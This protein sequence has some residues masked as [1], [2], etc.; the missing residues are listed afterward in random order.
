M[1]VLAFEKYEVLCYTRIPRWLRR[2]ARCSS[3][4]CRGAGHRGLH[5]TIALVLAVCWKQACSK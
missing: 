3:W 5:V 1:L 4:P 2:D